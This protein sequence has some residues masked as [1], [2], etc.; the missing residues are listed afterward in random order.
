MDTPNH[1]IIGRGRTG[2]I[3]AWEAG[4]AL[5]LYGADCHPDSVRREA[6]V[7]RWVHH[8]GLPAPAVFDSDAHDGLHRVGG[9]LGILYQRIDGPT[10][11]QDLGVRPWKVIAHSKTLAALHAE[12]HSVPGNGLPLMRDRIQRSIDRARGRVSEGALVSAREALRQLPDERQVCHGDF[13]PDNVILQEGGPIIIDWGPAS[14]GHPAAD[15]AW[16]VLLYRLGGV[17]PDTPPS[18]RVLLP[19]VRRWS[20]RVYLRAYFAL[21]GYSWQDVEAWLGLMA[22]LRLSDDFPEERRALVRRIEK[23]FKGGASRRSAPPE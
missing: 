9:R 22:L 8:A 17:P 15:V 19:V 7:S 1:T 12:V 13:H 4:R 20:L 18:L 23:Q 16:T 11:L 14:A 2:E 3:L 5:K 21:T 10:M 6:D